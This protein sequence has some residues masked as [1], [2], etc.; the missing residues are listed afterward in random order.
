MLQPLSS[1]GCGMAGSIGPRYS[2]MSSSMGASILAAGESG[3]VE[4]EGLRIGLSSTIFIPSTGPRVFVSPNRG[5]DGP[6]DVSGTGSGGG[7]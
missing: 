7:V 5:G 3:D 1:A 2:G 6:A 4:S